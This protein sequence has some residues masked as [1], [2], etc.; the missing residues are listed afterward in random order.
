[1]M[2]H[3]GRYTVNKPVLCPYCQAETEAEYVDVGVGMVQVTPHTCYDCG[4]ME[5]GPH[6]TPREL[7]PEEHRT[8]F[9]APID[10]LV[11]HCFHGMEPGHHREHM[12][13]APVAEGEIPF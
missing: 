8:G 9:Y 11:A 5:I 6:D 1:M 12:Q 4:A 3:P 2:I 10:A 13:Y 7:R